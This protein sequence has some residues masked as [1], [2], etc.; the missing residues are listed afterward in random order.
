MKKIVALFIELHNHQILCNPEVAYLYG[1]NAKKRRVTEWQKVHLPEKK[2]KS[3]G[4]IIR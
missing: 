2:K 3:R 4:I 1:L